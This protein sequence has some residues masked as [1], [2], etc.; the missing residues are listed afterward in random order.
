MILLTAEKLRVDVESPKEI[1]K[2][3]R[4]TSLPKDFSEYQEVD[5]TIS[6]S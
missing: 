5:A 2:L 4:K 1:I 6:N 3:N